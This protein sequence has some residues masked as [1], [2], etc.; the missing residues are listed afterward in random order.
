MSSINIKGNNNRVVIDG[1]DF[2]GSN[3]EVVDGVLKVDGKVLKKKMAHNVNMVVYG[4]VRTV[5]TVSGDVKV[6][7]DNVESIETISG[8]VV[9]KSTVNNVQTVSGDISTN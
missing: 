8:D 2:N 3:F 6:T 9:C 1:E 5:K 4:N 7:A